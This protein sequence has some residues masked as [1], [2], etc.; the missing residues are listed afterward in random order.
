MFKAIQIGLTT[1]ITV[2]Q[3]PSLPP[4]PEPPQIILVEVVEADEIATTTPLSISD[5]IEQYGLTQDVT[6]AEIELMKH[7]GFCE[8][9]YTQFNK[10]GSVFR[11]KITPKDV[12][13]YQINEYYNPSS[14]PNAYT[15]EGNIEEAF[16]LYK[17]QGTS[18]WSASK[19]CWG[20]PKK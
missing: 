13:V 17:A 16:K 20:K 12:G 8:S 5:Q 6:G 10:D 2:W 9:T 14:F 1:L 11:G 18:P 15:T 19:P 3:Q 4:T 7:I